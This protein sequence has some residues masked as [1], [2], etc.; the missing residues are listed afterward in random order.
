MFKSYC[1]HQSLP[2]YYNIQKE[3]YSHRLFCYDVLKSKRIIL[4]SKRGE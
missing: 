4:Q 3:N 1:L 2:V